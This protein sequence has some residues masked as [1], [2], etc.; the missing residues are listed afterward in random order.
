MCAWGHLGQ[1]GATWVVHNRDPCHNCDPRHTRDDASGPASG[2]C[3]RGCGCACAPRSP[4]GRQ[5]MGSMRWC[6][7]IPRRH[8]RDP[9]GI[10]ARLAAGFAGV[11]PSRWRRTAPTCPL[12]A[13]RRASDPLE[14]TRIPA[15]FAA[16]P[17]TTA[18]SIGLAHA[19]PCP[20]PESAC[21]PARVRVC[22]ASGDPRPR[23]GCRVPYLFPLANP[24]L[25]EAMRRAARGQPCGARRAGFFYC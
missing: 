24:D 10:A 4:G 9:R 1:G 23:F 21:A 3:P 5:C 13:T 7:G 19:C 2:A 11:L 8:K 17:P 14:R 25:L 15:R 12:P 22:P 18:T 6:W 20:S 16:T